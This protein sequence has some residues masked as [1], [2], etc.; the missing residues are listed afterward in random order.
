MSIIVC[1]QF[2]L[3][4]ALTCIECE[5]PMLDP[6]VAGLLGSVCS[7]DCAAGQSDRIVALRRRTHLYQR[8]LMCTCPVC[9]S[10][11]RPTDAERREWADYLAEKAS[12]H[13]RSSP[14]ER[15]IPRSEGFGCASPTGGTLATANRAQNPD[16]HSHLEQCTTPIYNASGSAPDRCAYPSGHDGDCAP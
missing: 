10:A 13:S 12:C 16:T 7:E 8:D 14:A 5:G 2:D 4:G 3:F 9:L 6:P 1:S 15:D 11:G